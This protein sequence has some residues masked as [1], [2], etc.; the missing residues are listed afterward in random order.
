MVQAIQELYNPAQLEVLY[1]AHLISIGAADDLATLEG[2]LDA[3]A[4]AD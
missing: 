2:A 4:L 1:R 3:A